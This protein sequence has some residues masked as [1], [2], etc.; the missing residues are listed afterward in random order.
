[1]TITRGTTRRN[2]LQWFAQGGWYFLVVALSLGILSPIPF[3]HAA[4]RLR[5]PLHW[6]T[7]LA[8]LAAVVA[9]FATSRPNE[10]SATGWLPMLILLTSLVYLFWLRRRVWPRAAT[11]PAPPAGTD[12]AVAAALAARS[13]RADARRIVADDPRLARDLRIGRPDLPRDYDDGGLVDLNTAP[14]RAI[15]ALCGIDAG[16]AQQIADARATA[17]VP[18]AEV[19][20]VFA[21]TE[22]PVGL[23]DHIR[24]RGITL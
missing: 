6:L 4:A 22:I 20:D 14:A 21:Y 9:W 5:N 13:R 24:D 23:W 2:P 19:D 7:P 11:A 18:F 10:P 15:A 8:Y 1:M 16:P 17:G 12:P 3:A